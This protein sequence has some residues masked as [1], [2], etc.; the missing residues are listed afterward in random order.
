MHGAPAASEDAGKGDGTPREP[1]LALV[2]GSGSSRADDGEADEGEPAHRAAAGED[3]EAQRHDEPFGGSEEEIP[4]GEDYLS[5][6]EGTDEG[7]DALA[8]GIPSG[9]RAGA[10]AMPA[11]SS[12]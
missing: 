3:E 9:F 2:A 7:T 1:R 6:D 5:W 10:R 12:P 11:I 8:P 4:S